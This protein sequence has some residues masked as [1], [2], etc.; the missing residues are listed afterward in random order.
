[1]FLLTIT[2]PPGHIEVLWKERGAEEDIEPLFQKQDIIAVPF[3]W[4]QEFY[5]D[6]KM[7]NDL[8][9]IPLGGAY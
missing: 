8:G 1:V 4:E 9:A 3:V 5:I 6:A 7:S 2:P